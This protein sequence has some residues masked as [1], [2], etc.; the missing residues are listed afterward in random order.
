MGWWMLPTGGDR[1]SERY[2]TTLND[3]IRGQRP[4]KTAK[5]RKPQKQQ[6][7]FKVPK[8][9]FQLGLKWKAFLA[10]PAIAYFCDENQTSWP[11]MATMAQMMGVHKDTIRDGVN[12]LVAAGVV[13]K[14]RQG[15]NGLQYA[16]RYTIQPERKWRPV[17]GDND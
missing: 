14:V 2:P 13:M 9:L 15:A 5:G 1:V 8:E 16:N 12:E 6:G 10:F 3:F 17:V 7:F 4:P 11:S